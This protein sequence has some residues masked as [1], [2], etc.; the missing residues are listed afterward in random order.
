MVNI[1]KIVNTFIADLLLTLSLLCIK[2][3]YPGQ[4]HLVKEIFHLRE[5]NPGKIKV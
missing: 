4:A 2:Y 1:S 3:Q 5:T